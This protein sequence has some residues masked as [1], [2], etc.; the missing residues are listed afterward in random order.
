MQKFRKSLPSLKQVMVTIIVSLV[1]GV[2]L[3]GFHPPAL[4]AL[5]MGFMFLVLLTW[6]NYDPD[7]WEQYHNPREYRLRTERD[8]LHKALKELTEA[9]EDEASPVGS[10][11]VARA[12]ESRQLLD[13]IKARY[14][15][16]TKAK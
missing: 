9:V 3:K 4:L 2:L 12:V 5:L 16:K 10:L 13:D 11:V 8:E 1:F 7:A 15:P 6:R 14:K